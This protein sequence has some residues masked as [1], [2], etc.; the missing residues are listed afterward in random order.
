MRSLVCN[1]VLFVLLA[2]AA[3]AHSAQA[4]QS[5]RWT[6]ADDRDAAFAHVVS[7]VN[8]RTGLQL[9]P[10]DFRLGEE[11]ELAFNDYRRYEQIAGELPVPVKDMSIRIW[12]EKQ[13]GALLQ[14]DAQVEDPAALPIGAGEFESLP[15]KTSLGS[16]KTLALVRAAIAAGAGA[17]DPAITKLESEDAWDPE[18]GGRLVRFVVAKGRRGRHQVRIDVETG[19]VLS[20]RYREFPRADRTTPDEISPADEFSLPALIYPFYEEYKG[21]RLA[22]RRAMLKYLKTTR[23]APT[24]DPYLPLRDRHYFAGKLDAVRGQT[25]AGQAEG[26]W[27]YDWLKGRIAELGR[28]IPSAPNDLETGAVLQGRYVTVNIHPA[29]FT[30]FPGITIE[31][32]FSGHVLFDWLYDAAADDWEVVPKASLLGKPLVGRRAAWDR[33]AQRLPVHDPAVYINDGFD[34]VQVYYAVNQL[35]EALRPLGFRDPDLGERPFHAFL[36]NPDIEAADNAYYDDDTINFTTYSPGEM[37][38]ARDNLTIWHELGHGVM[39]RLM[40][41][42]LNLADTGG[43]SEGMADFVAEMV[44]EASAFDRDFP[45]RGDQRIINE[46]GFYLTNEVHDDG[47]AYGGTMKALLDGAVRAYGRAGVRKTVDVVLEAMRLSRDHPALTADLWF[48]RL[49]FADELGRPGVRRRGELRPLIEAA[50][51]SRNFA[52]ESERAVFSLKYGEAEIVDGEPGSRGEEIPVELAADATADFPLTVQVRDGAHYQFKYPVSVKVFFESGPLQGAIDWDGE[53][54]EP[55]VYEI[56]ASGGEATVP[57]RI[58][59]KCDEINR[60]DGT[61]SDFAYVQI[62]N[63]DGTTAVAKKRFYLK[64]KTL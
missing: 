57:L 37:N 15:T 60:T 9:T 45:G 27:S 54:Q 12:T 34:E 32:R 19:V 39:D 63:A 64:V 52:P 44:L 1:L 29:A 7:E 46:T 40:G 43:L 56:A 61:C 6:Y 4:A 8:R 47:E 31:P 24:A 22:R 21:E 53:E 51:A 14:V 2:A 18:N 48:E 17:R 38:M 5:V 62:W 49:L 23:A 50:L 41:A 28:A 33:P 59:G 20:A 26:Y 42:K 58:K 11:R 3:G 16:E 35:F 10:A 36:F 55:A 30:S 13:S 25:P